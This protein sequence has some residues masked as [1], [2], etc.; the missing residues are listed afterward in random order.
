MVMP[1]KVQRL[2]HAEQLLLLGQPGDLAVE[3]DSGLKHSNHHYSLVVPPGYTV[4]RRLSVPSVSRREQTE[5]LQLAAEATIS[6]SLD[7]YLVDYWHI[8]REH[9]GMAAIPRDLLIG[10]Q[11]LVDEAGRT[12]TRIQVPELVADLKDG[13]VL[14]MLADAV[15]VCD[16]RESVLMDWQ[17]MPRANGDLA[18]ERVLAFGR[19]PGDIDQIVLRTS[20]VQ[21]PTYVD[22]LSAACNRAMPRAEIKVLEDSLTETPSRGRTLCKFSQFVREQANQAA[23]P[24]RQLRAVLSTLVLLAAIGSFLYVQLRDLEDQAARAEHTASLLKVQAVRSS[25]IANRVRKLNGEVREVRALD[26]NRVI[27]LLDDLLELMP[28]TIRLAGV[29]QIDRRGVLSMDGL[30]EKEQDIGSF[31]REL[32]RQP[33]VAAVRLQSVTGARRDEEKGKGTRFR[34]RVQLDAP[35]WVPMAENES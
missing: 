19:P 6:D 15:M 16:W 9:Y 13:L 22:E 21:Q 24:A 5:A 34:L 11:T 10:Y 28:A 25:R 17:V 20:G 8:D 12:A 3:V 14:W 26:D 30:A 29:L 33:Q 7:A 18:L 31:V 23:S 2:A 35:L 4:L 32:S 1:A 27:A